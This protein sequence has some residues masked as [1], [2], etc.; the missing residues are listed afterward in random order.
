MDRIMLISVTLRNG[1]QLAKT[2][3]GEYD[4]NEVVT[5]LIGP[6]NK[7]LVATVVEIE[8]MPQCRM[9]MAT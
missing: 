6:G 2:V 3:K 1:T 7:G 9:E 5:G 8:V 4:L